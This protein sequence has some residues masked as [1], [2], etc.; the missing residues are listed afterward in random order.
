MCGPPDAEMRRAALPGSPDRKPDFNKLEE[1]SEPLQ[2]IQARK[3]R[4]LPALWF[5]ASVT[6]ARLAYA[7]AP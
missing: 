4:R 7:V 2:H 1:T 6:I 5:A 3:Q